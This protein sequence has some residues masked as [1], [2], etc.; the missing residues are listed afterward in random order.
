MCQECGHW[1]AASD[2]PCPECTS[3]PSVAVSTLKDIIA[4]L[5][6]TAMLDDVKVTCTMDTEDPSL[7]KIFP[8]RSKLSLD[9]YLEVEGKVSE[10]KDPTHKIF[11][12]KDGRTQEISRAEWDELNPGVEPVTWS[13]ED[14]PGRVFHYNIT[15]NLNTMAEAADL[16]KPLWRPDEIGITKAV[17]LIPY[18]QRGINTL[19]EDPA[20]FKKLNP[21]NGWGNYDN[22]VEFVAKYLIA[23]RENP[24]ANVRVWR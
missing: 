21:E 5:D 12:R 16:Y 19:L 18:L 23:C 8:R 22:L 17:Q 7:G 20:K 3:T 15:H 2:D 14:E 1:L 13:G 11:V 6:G 24:E 4:A 9:V 10:K